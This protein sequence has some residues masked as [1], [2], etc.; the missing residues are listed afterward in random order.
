MEPH[1]TQVPLLFCPSTKYFPYSP[2][3]Q[4]DVLANVRWVFAFFFGQQRFF[5]PWKSPVYGS[6][7]LCYCSIINNHPNW[8]YL[9]LQ[10]CSGCFCSS[11]TSWMSWW[12]T[13]GDI[14]VGQWCQGRSTNVLCWVSFVEDL[15]HCEWLLM[16]VPLKLQI[17]TN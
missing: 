1:F 12:F 2:G 6:L 15:R 11:V 16:L 7:S 17:D 9:G 10:F 5:Y 13:F 8:G 14:L 4:R 3:D